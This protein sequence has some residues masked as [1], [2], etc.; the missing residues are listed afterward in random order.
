MD[1]K[2]DQLLKPLSAGI[3]SVVAGGNG[4]TMNRKGTYSWR[5]Y[6]LIAVVMAGCMGL[7]GCIQKEE[8]LIS[9]GD[10]NMS[11]T[12]TPA[13]EITLPIS[14]DK[15]ELSFLAM[16]EPYIL[17]TMESHADMR[18]YEVA[19]EKTNIHINWKEASYTDP[20]KKMNSMIRMGQTADIIWDAHLYA[21]DS[22]KKL[23]DEGILLSLNP[24]IEKYAPNL[25]KLLEDN[26]EVLEEISTDDGRI[27]MFPEV[28]LDP[29]TRM[30]SGF[31]VR[32]DWLKRAGLDTPETIEDWY[33]MLKTF[34]QMDMNGNGKADECF[35]SM[36]YENY[37]QSLTNFA[38]AYGLLDG[39]N[40]FFIQD[41]VVKYAPYEDDYRNFLAEMARWYREGLIDAEFCTQDA[42]RFADK[43]ISGVGGGFYGNLSGNMGRFLSENMDDPEY[44]LV[45]VSA[46]KAPDGKVYATSSGYAKIVSHG[47]SISSSNPYV[48]ET[49]KWLDWHYSEEG[50]TLFNWGVEGE[51]FEIADGKKQFTDLILNNPNGWS[52][53]E[54]AARYAGGVLTQMP[55]VEDTEVYLQTKVLP[56]Q[57]HAIALWSEADTEWILPMLYL[58]TQEDETISSMRREITRYAEE[59]F[60]KYVMGIE[61][62]DSFGEFQ[63]Q[64][65]TMGIEQVLHSYQ[66]AY[67]ARIK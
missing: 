51:S 64:L 39:E 25:K 24:Y 31:A 65:K 40:A 29:R 16:S 57:K 3:I 42:Q 15:I 23:L 49:V 22:V 45:A 54:A 66:E 18:V 2:N 60:Y 52:V 17:S 7:N 1:L 27:F 30:N 8:G 63:K 43:M 61:N 33:H 37:S 19:E 46:P 11:L 47:A 44:D 59:Q 58:D 41:G 32:A 9:L 26:P 20:R 48:V 55:I 50:S 35:V 56:Q 62:L 4:G 12:E 13:E 36:G 53:E 5:T 21:E 34:Q 14:K 6:K 28:R 10:G 67:D 38:V